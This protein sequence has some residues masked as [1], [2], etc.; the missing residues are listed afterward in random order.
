M[1]RDDI[2]KLALEAGFEEYEW[3]SL[4][5][6]SELDQTLQVGEYP[7]GEAVFNFAALVAA[8]ERERLAQPQRTHWEGCEE[9]HPECRKPERP[10]NCGTS[11]CSCIECV[12]EQPEQEPVAWHHP[13]CQGECIACL[14][15]RAVQ[16]AYGT[17]GL[18]YLLRHVTTVTTP[19]RREW[20]G[21]TDTDIEE[22]WADEN[23]GR[24]ATSYA[25]EAKL[26]EKNHDRT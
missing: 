4:S 14:I 20:A 1:T 21:L 7:V 26:K 18:D 17:Q 12:M 13:E 25:I 19:P 3:S 5:G 22:V 10:P 8:A 9:V 11:Y 6:D 15:Q 16:D 2:I 23:L 24:Y